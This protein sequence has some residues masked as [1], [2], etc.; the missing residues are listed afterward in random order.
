MALIITGYIVP[1]IH[2]GGFK[3]AIFAAVVLG[4][5]NTFIK[6][7]LSFLSA[8]INF[9]TLGL[10]S[11]VINAV[12]LWMVTLFVKS[13][14]IDDALSA[15]LGAIVLSLV[16]TVLSSLSADLLGGRKR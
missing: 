14:Q 1:G 16:S 6:P 2:I 10:F 12:V 8:P 9:L 7:I 5:I 3:S 11:F 15:I 4:L 13:F